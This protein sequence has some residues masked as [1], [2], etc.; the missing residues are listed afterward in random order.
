MRVKNTARIPP[1]TVSR[2]DINLSA[3]IFILFNICPH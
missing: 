2:I 1:K 3:K